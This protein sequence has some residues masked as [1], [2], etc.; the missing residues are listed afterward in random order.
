M[1]DADEKP[2]FL[3]TVSGYPKDAGVTTSPWQ[4]LIVPFA[5]IDKDFMDYPSWG[6]F[7]GC[8]ITSLGVSPSRAYSWMKER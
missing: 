7:F 3:Q 2:V 6:S 8:R 4:T 1:S 5:L